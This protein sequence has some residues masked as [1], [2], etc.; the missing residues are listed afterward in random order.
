MVGQKMS[1]GRE[2]WAGHAT[3]SFHWVLVLTCPCGQSSCLLCMS[4]RSSYK[5][6]AEGGERTR[7]VSHVSLKG[8][9]EIAKSMSN[10][11]CA[12]GLSILAEIPTFSVES[13]VVFISMNEFIIAVYTFQEIFFLIP[14][15][16]FL[17]K[18]L[19]Q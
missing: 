15:T 16:H 13:S 8:L 14:T 12:G 9:L 3:A 11:R 18:T 19:I 2:E 6:G 4:F 10:C 7:A 1:R 5:E 17:L